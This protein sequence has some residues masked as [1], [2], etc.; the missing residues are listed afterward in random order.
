MSYK[1]EAR[2]AQH[3]KMERMGLRKEHKKST[4]SDT[5]PYDGVPQL[6]SGNAGQRPKTPSKFKR[7]GKVAEAEG[8]EAK[9]HLGHKPRKASGGLLSSNPQQRKK[10]VAA[11]ASRKKREGLA[12]A[13][14]KGLKQDLGLAG[15]TGMFHKKGGKVDSWE[16]SK[17]DEAQDKKL[18]KKHHM[19]MKEWE[20]SSMDKKH[21]RQHSPKGLKHGGRMK[22]ND[23]GEITNDGMKN[24]FQPEVST[25]NIAPKKQMYEVYDGHTGNIVGTYGSLRTASR[26][27]D[28]RDNEY[29]GYR[30]RKR[31]INK[32]DGGGITDFLNSK[33]YQVGQSQRYPSMED[34]KTI[35]PRMFGENAYVPE[36]MEDRMGSKSPLRLY[37]LPLGQ[38]PS[39]SNAG[40]GDVSPAM[41]NRMKRI[42]DAQSAQARA[43]N[44]LESQKRAFGVTGQKKGGRIMRKSG[45]A[46]KPK[47]TNVII[48]LSTDGGQARP[49]MPIGMP[50]VAPPVPPMPMV[51]PA[52][53]P[54]GAPGM[55]APAGAGPGMGAMAGPPGGAPVPPM[56]KAGGRI[57]QSFPKYQETNFGSGS[58][59]G[60]LE[61]RKWPPAKG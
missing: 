24:E 30:Y 36:N 55:G 27:V 47:G 49:P 52:M 1:H 43:D 60:R 45:G 53:P 50:P 10:I 42:M 35:T 57:N 31:P 58:G 38:I 37:P 61:K 15:A 28:R 33:E 44:A 29:G 48:N 19:S 9:H 32:D 4:F 39:Q 14:P 59:L 3:E 17:A 54:G 11:L 8:M 5:E 34:R 22:K 6:D 41:A 23:G 26:A 46:A 21:D 51:P 25:Q 56:R 40:T 18:A 12:S 20:A 7:G 2:K 13:P 16:G